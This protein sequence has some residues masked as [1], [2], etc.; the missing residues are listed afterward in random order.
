MKLFVLNRNTWNYTT[1]S[2]LYALDCNSWYYI[3][4]QKHLRKKYTKTM[5]TQM[6]NESNSLTSRHKITAE[7][8]S[9]R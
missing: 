8:L 7:V 1:A 5:K 4:V 2:K 6:Y 3:T 9:W